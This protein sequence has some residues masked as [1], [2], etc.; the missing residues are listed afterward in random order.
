MSHRGQATTATHSEGTGVQ[1]ITHREVEWGSHTVILM[2]SSYN[3]NF[4]VLKPC[5][6][7]NRAMLKTNYMHLLTYISRCLIILHVSNQ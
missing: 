5:I 7:M 2:E 4:T 1:T 3:T 6:V